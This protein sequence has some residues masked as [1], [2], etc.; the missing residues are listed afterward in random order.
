MIKLEEEKYKILINDIKKLLDNVCKDDRVK[1][2]INPVVEIA[3][4]MAIDLNADTQIVVIAA[5]LHDITKMF[6]E[7]KNHHLIGAEYAGNFLTN[8]DIND[9]IIEKIKNCIK[10]HRGSSEFTRNTIE[11][12]IV[13]TAD[14]V[15]HIEHPLTLFYAWYGQR[16]CQINE[17]ADGIINKLQ[18]SWNKIEFEYVKDELKEKY[19]NLINMLTE[20]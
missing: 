5:Y 3:H 16:Q 2:H 10:K 4:R 7:R 18:R 19:Q 8:Y 20:R 11:E 14:A 12:K 17:G 9:E 15:A 13:A 1:Y 6:G